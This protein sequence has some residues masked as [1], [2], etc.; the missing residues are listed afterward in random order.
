MPREYL[1]EGGPDFCIEE[2]GSRVWIE[3][4]TI[5]TG[6][7]RD[8]VAPMKYEPEGPAHPVPNDQIVL[9]Y[10][11]AIRD[12]HC[13]HLRHLSKGLVQANEPFIIAINGV[14]IPIEYWAA[15]PDIPF[16]IQSVLP[17]GQYSIT[18]DTST[19]KV[20]REGPEHRTNILKLSGS[21]VPT[22]VFMDCTFSL[23]SG[24]IFSDIHPFYCKNARLSSL[25]LLH[26]CEPLHALKEGW[27]KSGIEW[28]LKK[29]QDNYILEPRRII[30]AA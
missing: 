2:D 13:N 3:A 9:R 18:F 14:G 26:N 15:M 11:S 12:K 29:E 27:L 6:T 28:R 7:G 21:V 23:I 24:L 16:A 10:C 20:I 8:S 19:K 22:N 1:P 30:P 5:N 4:V 17:L 25:S